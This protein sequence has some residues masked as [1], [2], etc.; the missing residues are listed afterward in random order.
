[1]YLILRIVPPGNMDDESRELL[2]KFAKANS[3]EDIRK[4]W[5]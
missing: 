3:Q 5:R 2:V 4:D 1:M